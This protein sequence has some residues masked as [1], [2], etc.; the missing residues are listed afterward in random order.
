MARV[1]R[2]DPEQEKTITHKECGAVIGYYENEVVDK[3]ISDYGG[4]SDIYHHL[5]CPHCGKVIQWSGKK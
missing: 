3:S 4:G 5:T 1:I 2:I